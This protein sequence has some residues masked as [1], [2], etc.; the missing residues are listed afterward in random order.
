[1]ISLEIMVL[2]ET[3]VETRVDRWVLIAVDRDDTSEVRVLV[4]VLSLVFNAESTAFNE[5]DAALTAVDRDVTSELRVLISVLSPVFNAES[6]ALNE[7]DAALTAVDRDITSEVRTLISAAMDVINI[8]LPFVMVVVSDGSFPMA[9][10]MSASV[11]I[12]ADSPSPAMAAVLTFTYDSVA[13]TAEWNVGCTMKS[14]GPVTVTL[15][16]ENTAFPETSSRVVIVAVCRVALSKMAL[17]MLAVVMLA[18]VMLAIGI[19]VMPVR[20]A[21]WTG[22][23]NKCKTSSAFLRSR[24]SLF[25]T[26]VKSDRWD[27]TSEFVTFPMTISVMRVQL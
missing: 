5:T 2:M 26:A 11:F 23:F 8:V 13:I 7:T 19:V 9:V 17:P 1:M 22:A 25:N 6:T 3:S 18:V 10:A 14:H 24:I 20:L 21:S 27:T 12:V 15:P 4:S 16:S